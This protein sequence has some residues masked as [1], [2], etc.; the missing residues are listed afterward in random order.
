MRGLSP[1]SIPRWFLLNLNLLRS[2]KMRKAHM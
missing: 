2:S 1:Y